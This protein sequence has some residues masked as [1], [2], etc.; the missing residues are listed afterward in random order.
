M[1]KERSLIKTMTDMFNNK[2]SLKKCSSLL[3]RALTESELGI[4]NMLI[5]ARYDQS[6]DYARLSETADKCSTCE[7]ARLF[8]ANQLCT[9]QRML[10]R[11]DYLK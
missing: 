7:Y 8:G 4:A 3:E 9:N 10:R 11:T 1:T 2:P 5:M 6:F